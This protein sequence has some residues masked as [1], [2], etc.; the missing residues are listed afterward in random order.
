VDPGY[1]QGYADLFRRHWW[2]RAREALLLRELR[3][4]RPANGWRSVL[5]IG[6][7]DGLFFDRLREFGEVE[8]VEPDASLVTAD[9]PHRA[10]IHVGPF[11]AAFRP[12]KRYSVTLMLDVL[13]HLADPV[14]ALRHALSLLEPGGT[15]VAT[16]PAFRALWTGH[17]DLNH[18]LTRYTRRSFRALARAAGLRIDRERYFFHWTCPVKL[19]VRLKEA[20]RRRPPGGA[21]PGGAPV[22]KLAI[23]GRGARARAGNSPGCGV[24]LNLQHCAGLS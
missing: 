6:C 2:W 14:G 8:G 16:V 10:R 9:G 17:D 22:R 11:D 19:L 12:G 20:V 21:R 24:E 3:R 23:G 15:F 1:G 5:D 18:H 7:G 4:A 13:E